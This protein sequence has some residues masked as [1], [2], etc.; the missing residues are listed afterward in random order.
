MESELTALVQRAEAASAANDAATADRLFALLYHELHRL[1]EHHLRHSGPTMTLGS[2]TLLH[3][4]YLSVS[5]RGRDGVVFPDRSRFY[6]YASRAMRTLVVD[7]ARRRHAQKRG[8][9]LEITLVGDEPPSAAAL[10]ESEELEH[11]GDALEELAATDPALASLV[12]MHFF[13]GLTF[14][15]IATIRGVSEKTVQRDW[16]KAR[17]LLQ[18][19]LSA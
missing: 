9:E 18:N 7:Y 17:L 16:R 15:E 5:G 6:A 10:R 2:T 4:A 3:E 12:D 8:R 19:A 13:C 14:T 11:L 1:A